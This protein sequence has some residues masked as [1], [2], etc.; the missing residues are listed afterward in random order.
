M[1]H[2]RF[3][4]AGTND[5]V[6][7]AGAELVAMGATPVGS[8]CFIASRADDAETWQGFAQHH[9]SVRLSVALFREF[10]DEFVQAI[11][12]E[13]GTTNLSRRSVLPEVFGCFDEEGEPIPKELLAAAA[14]GVAADRLA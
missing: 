13:R 9:Q 5:A 11:V 10:E 3:T 7:A 8:G 14:C 2:Y 4:L 12:T 1:F 6:T